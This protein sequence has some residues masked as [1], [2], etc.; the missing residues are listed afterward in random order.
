MKKAFLIS[1]MAVIVFVNGAG[2]VLAQTDFTATSTDPLNPDN[3]N[4]TNVRH[5]IVN[6]GLPGTIYAEMDGGASQTTNQLQVGYWA[7]LDTG[8]CTF[9]GGTFTDNTVILG[10]RGGTGIVIITNTAVIKH[11]D[12]PG[13]S[14]W[15]IGGQGWT[16]RRSIGIVRMYPGTS[17][18]GFKLYLPIH[19]A[20]ATKLTPRGFWYQSGGAVT[21]DVNV[22][23]GPGYGE[24]EISGGT[25][26]SHTVIQVGTGSAGTG[27][28]HVVGSSSDVS[29][30]YYFRAGSNARLKYTLDSGGVTPIIIR[31]QHPV[32]F[33]LVTNCIIDM[34]FE[35]ES[36]RDALIALPDGDAGRVFNLVGAT[37]KTFSAVWG[38]GSLSLGAGDD[39][40]WV[41]QDDGV[42]WLQAKFTTLPPAQGTVI[43]VK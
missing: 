11:V 32:D 18:T 1:S 36:V 40:D 31:E 23:L 19:N 30:R 3:F 38:Y 8:V 39:E 26:S 43:A 6:A 2:N 12:G 5:I 24:F 4:N 9:A 10:Y 42:T 29:I 37:G 41:L 27:V 7:G 28:F 33:S 22:G 34:E 21:S 25:L 15:Q 20:D 14:W 13:D 16:T 35:S 17:L